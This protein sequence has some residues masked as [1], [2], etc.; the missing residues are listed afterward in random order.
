MLAVLA[1]AKPLSGYACHWASL[2][3]HDFHLESVHSSAMV[4]A[5]LHKRAAASISTTVLSSVV[6]NALIANR[7]R[8]AL[9]HV[10]V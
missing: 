10:L 8:K 1:S 4:E 7:T 9:R 5:I 2:A 3:S 6:A